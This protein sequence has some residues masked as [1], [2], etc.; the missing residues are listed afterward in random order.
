MPLKRENLIADDE[1]RVWTGAAA[2]KLPR[3]CRQPHDLV[4]VTGQQA[5]AGASRQH[6]GLLTD[7][8][9]MLHPDAPAIVGGPGL[10]AEEVGN[11]LVPEA[12]AYHFAALGKGLAQERDELGDPRQLI[13]NAV[14]A[15]RY[16][17]GIAG[18]R[19]WK[20]TLLRVIAAELKRPGTR[21][22]RAQAS[23]V[24]DPLK[25]GRVIAMGRLK[26]VQHRIGPQDAD[27]QGGPGRLL[28]R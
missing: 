19:W 20:L 9:S 18:S 1:P 16:Q 11:E 5:K 6:P 27:V 14:P 12:D 26:L 13:I 21:R 4:P 25:H 10:S 28:L 23:L 2:G 7:H 8:C 3:P 24:Q 22:I 15:A 17:V